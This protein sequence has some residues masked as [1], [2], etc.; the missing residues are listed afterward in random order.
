MTKVEKDNFTYIG[1]GF[2]VKVFSDGVK[3]QLL[4]E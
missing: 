1:E 3:C 2:F 4:I